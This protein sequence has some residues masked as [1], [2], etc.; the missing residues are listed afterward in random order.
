MNAWWKC[1]SLV[2]LFANNDDKQ[3]VV[4]EHVVI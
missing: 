4:V 3:N 1:N 2:T